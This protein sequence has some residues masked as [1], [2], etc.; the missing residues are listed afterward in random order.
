MMETR[1]TMFEL[2]LGQDLKRQLSV[3]GISDVEKLAPWGDDE[4]PQLVLPP[5]SENPSFLA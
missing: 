1:L 2:K 5:V 4:P 3:G